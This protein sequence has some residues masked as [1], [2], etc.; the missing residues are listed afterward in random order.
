MGEVTHPELL[1]DLATRFVSGWSVK[2]MVRSIVLSRTY[3]LA[4]DAD[5]KLIEADPQNRL[6]ARHARRR[7]E[8]EMLRDT[9]CSSADNCN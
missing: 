1:D 7:L 2:Q 3:Q 8:A 9:C 4:S 6:L 5:A